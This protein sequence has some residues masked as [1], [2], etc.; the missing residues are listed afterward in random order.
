MDFMD[1]KEWIRR[2]Q[3]LNEINKYL[4]MLKK[5]SDL[6]IFKSKQEIEELENEIKKLIVL[7]Y[8]R[9]I[10]IKLV[11]KNVREIEIKRFHILDDNEIWGNFMNRKLYK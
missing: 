3:I 8:G 1:E 6:K 5:R 9:L 7:K 4:S 11:F 10:E 2:R